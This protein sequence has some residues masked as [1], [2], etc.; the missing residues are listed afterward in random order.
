M[1]LVSVA[2]Y[3]KHN[4][5]RSVK[6]FDNPANVYSAGTIYKCLPIAVC[7]LMRTLSAAVQVF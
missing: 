5:P 6:V 3:A 4:T 2:I 7:S 1:V